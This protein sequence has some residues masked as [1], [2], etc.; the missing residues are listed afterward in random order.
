MT[1]IVRYFLPL[2][3][4]TVGRGSH[5]SIQCI[6]IN[7]DALLTKY[8]TGVGEIRVQCTATNIRGFISSLK[9]SVWNSFLRLAHLTN[10]FYAVLRNYAGGFE[11]TVAWRFI[12]RSHITL[13][14]ILQHAWN[15]KMAQVQIWQVKP[16]SSAYYSVTETLRLTYRT[17]F[18]CGSVDCLGGKDIGSLVTG[19]VFSNW[20]QECVLRSGVNLWYHK[21]KMVLIIL[22]ALVAHC[23]PTVTSCSDGLMWDFL[24]TSN[25]FSAS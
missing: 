16:L 10:M 23:R 18:L 3:Q 25:C 13:R 11:G 7:I 1:S 4:F 14:F 21:N 9:K 12:F 24:Q 2:F 20:C 6:V 5:L 15:V 22:V 8:K 17:V 19:Q